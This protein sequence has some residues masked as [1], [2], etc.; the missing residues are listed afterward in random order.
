MEMKHMGAFLQTLRKE[1]NWTQE[2]LG[3]QLH[4]SAKTI[5]RWETGMYMPPVEMLLSMSEL[6]G[7]SMNELVA[8][9]RQTPDTLPRVADANLAAALQE[10]AAFKLQDKRQ[11][12]RQKWLRE[13]RWTLVVLIAV[14]CL[15]QIVALRMDRLEINALLALLLIAAVLYL[16]NRRDDYVEHHLFDEMLE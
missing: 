15:L 12:W 4:V 3:E 8:G 13:H 16:C 1:R 14:H 9:E 7:L 6:Y 10:N 5:S 2:Q 11:Y